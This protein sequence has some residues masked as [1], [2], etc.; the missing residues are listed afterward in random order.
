M[1][2]LSSQQLP[3]TSHEAPP[4]FTRSLNRSGF[5]S[6]TRI[7][8]ELRSMSVYLETS[9]SGNLCHEVVV[10][11][12]L[13][14]VS[15]QTMPRIHSIRHNRSDTSSWTGNTVIDPTVTCSWFCLTTSPTSNPHFHSRAV[16]LYLLPTTWFSCGHTSSCKSRPPAPSTPDQLHTSDTA[17]FTGSSGS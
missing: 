9:I 13:F 5:F 10:C 7:V 12:C 2:I 3:V 16:A 17:G 15:L 6:A 8:S 11:H 4:Q 14:A 1:V